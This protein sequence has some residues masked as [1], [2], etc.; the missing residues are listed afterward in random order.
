MSQFSI[1]LA[2]LFHDKNVA[3]N[4]IPLNIGYLANALKVT[5]KDSC[6]IK[7][8]KYSYDL[9]RALETHQP[10]MVCLSNYI[11][12]ARLSLRFARYIKSRYPRT[13]VVMGGPNV[14]HGS[15]GLKAFLEKHP[16]VD[17]YIPLTGELPLVD[18]TAALMKI[19]PRTHAC[20]V[21]ENVDDIAGVYINV[22][23]YSYV[24]YDPVLFKDS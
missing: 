12:N 3:T 16:E 21:L 13:V 4:V 14:R 11:W 5:F 7:L 17:G 22:P 8:F 6:E 19:G 9:G 18:L 15:D 1:F 20:A 10:D 23:D 2:D 24:P